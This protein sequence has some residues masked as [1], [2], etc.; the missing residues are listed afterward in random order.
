[1]RARGKIVLRRPSGNDYVVVASKGGV[2]ENPG[3]CQNLL[4]D[5]DVKIPVLDGIIPVRARTSSADDE[6]RVCGT[7]AAQSPR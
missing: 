5:R 3:W 4:A 7:M 1:L 6:R 2:S